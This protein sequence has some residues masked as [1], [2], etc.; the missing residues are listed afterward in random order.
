MDFLDTPVS[1]AMTREV[2]T[3]DPSLNAKVALD[4]MMDKGVHILPVSS[5]IAGVG[6][7]VTRH[8]IRRLL[9]K[10][11]QDMDR[12]GEVPSEPIREV[13]VYFVHKV[14]PDTPIREVIRL[15]DKHHVRAMP[16]VDQGQA[17]GIVTRG[18]LLRYALR[19]SESESESEGGA[20]EPSA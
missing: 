5:G 1:E 20:T 2:V 11:E 10:M 12:S 6:G 14:K 17:V 3:I 19:R 9:E 16:V 13:M 4:T 7:I 18:D 15:M 8:H